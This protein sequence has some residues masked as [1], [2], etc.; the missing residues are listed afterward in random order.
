MPG[1]H[2]RRQP[3]ALQSSC[4]LGRQ[5]WQPLTHWHQPPRY[6]QQLLPCP[7]CRSCSCCLCTSLHPT[8]YSL[9]ACLLACLYLS[10]FATHT[11]LH[12]LPLLPAGCFPPRWSTS[13]SLQAGWLA[14]QA[15]L[16]QAHQTQSSSC[17]M[18]LLLLLPRT[19][20]LCSA[21]HAAPG[22]A[23]PLPLEPV[24]LPPQLTVGR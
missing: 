9:A 8:S 6:V 4:R 15:T 17:W 20:C 24:G 21:V 1:W 16:R 19:A 2:L 3:H 23:A 11:L 22:A 10:G 14:R 5:H 13:S 12:C 7:A 18:L